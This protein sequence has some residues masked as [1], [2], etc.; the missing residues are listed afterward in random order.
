[1]RNESFSSAPQLK[2]IS[3]GGASIYMAAEAPAHLERAFRF[4]VPF[5]GNGFPFELFSFALP[6][7]VLPSGRIVACD[8][9]VVPDMIPFTV[10]LPAGRAKCQLSVAR[11][12]SGD[13]RVAFAWLGGEASRVARW[14][15]ALRGD[16]DP[17]RLEPDGYFGYPV[18]SGTGGYMDAETSATLLTLGKNNDQ[19]WDR[20][21]AALEVTQRNT[22]SWASFLP[23][24]RGANVLAFSSGFGDGLYPTYLGVD[25]AGQLCGF[26]TDF[27]VAD[28]PPATPQREHHMPRPWWK[29]WKR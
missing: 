15:L 20:L 3:L 18:D 29:F 26:L 2:R 19:W 5:Q 24:D 1:L 13:E 21:I 7:L 22:W 8:P 4:G 17:T 10:T 25:S 28:P 9:I 11:L 23:T 16:Q 6:D 14:E 12:D 27:L